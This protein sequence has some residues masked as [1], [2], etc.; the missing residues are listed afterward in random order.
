MA[1]A[2]CGH[3]KYEEVEQMSLAQRVA[4]IVANFLGE[5]DE[6]EVT[7]TLTLTLTPTP[8]P[9]PPLPHPYP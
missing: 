2:L 5:Q 6:E 1:L 4:G 8:T 3:V 9:T 7:L